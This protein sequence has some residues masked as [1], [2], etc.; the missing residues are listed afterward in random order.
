M[1]SDEC[2]SGITI[3]LTTVRILYQ[4]VFSGAFRVNHIE[5]SFGFSRINFLT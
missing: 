3:I 2:D 1:W 5:N 4:N